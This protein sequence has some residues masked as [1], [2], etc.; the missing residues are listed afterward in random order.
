MG[1]GRMRLSRR[2]RA[3]G[4]QG[5]RPFSVIRRRQASDE[6]HL[7][8]YPTAIGFTRAGDARDSCLL[9][10]GLRSGQRRRRQSMFPHKSGPDGSRKPSSAPYANAA[11]WLPAALLTTGL[12]FATVSEAAEAMHRRTPPEPFKVANIHFETNA[13]ACDMGIQIA[14]DTDGITQGTVKDPKGHT[15]YEFESKGGMKTLGGQ[16]EGFL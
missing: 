16:T 15:I 2:R 9:H 8:P 6:C 4:P 13:S 1:P 5:S 12:T 7:R 14:F 10:N 11:L 3:T